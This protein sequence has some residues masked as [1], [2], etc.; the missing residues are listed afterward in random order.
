MENDDIKFERI[1]EDDYSTDIW[2]YDMNKHKNGPVEVVIHYKPG[3]NKD[4]KHMEAELKKAKEERQAL[5]KQRL[6]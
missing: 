6:G 3:Y 2:K 4:K 5:M 1:F